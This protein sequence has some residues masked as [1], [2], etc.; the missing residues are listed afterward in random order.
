MSSERKESRSK[1]RRRE[2]FP[3][4]PMGVRTEKP[5]LGFLIEKGEEEAHDFPS[6]D[7]E[8]ERERK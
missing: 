7:L 3:Y 8:K 1:A 5:L 4:E 6:M 2:F